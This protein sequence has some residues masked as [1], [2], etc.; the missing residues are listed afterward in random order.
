MSRVTPTPD[1]DLWKPLLLRAVPA[2]GFGLLT[3]FWPDLPE[4][5]RALATGSYLV[6]TGIAVMLLQRVVR[7]G[8]PAAQPGLRLQAALLTFGGALIL[9]IHGLWSYLSIVALTMLLTG[10][11]EVYLG[12][13][14]RQRTALSRDWMMTGGVAMAAGLLLP[15][16]GQ[17][18]ER[19][20]SGVVGGSAVMIGVVLMLA[21]L[22]YRHDAVAECRESHPLPGVE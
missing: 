2:L 13:C 20:P 14:Y 18:A 7:D 17:A 4:L 16:M 21:A 10:A 8:L 9:V 15:W 22:S 3:V 5:G 6:L 12:W 19:A 1:P 11:I